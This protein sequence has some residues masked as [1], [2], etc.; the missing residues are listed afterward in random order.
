[1]ELVERLAD[2]FA[3]TTHDDLANYAIVKSREVIAAG[4]ARRA[5]TPKPIGVAVNV[6]NCFKQ[7]FEMEYLNPTL[8]IDPWRCLSRR[9][10]CCYHSLGQYPDTSLADAIRKI[11]SDPFFRLHSLGGTRAIYDFLVPHYPRIADESVVDGHHACSILRETIVR[12]PALTQRLGTH[13]AS[14]VSGAIGES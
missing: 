5:I 3:L 13:V 1:M 7:S 8:E 2:E 11:N 4:R 14:L 10:M 9:S 6:K 12:D